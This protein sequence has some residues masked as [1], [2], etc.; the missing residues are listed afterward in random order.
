ME[1]TQSVQL[2]KS[3]TTETES[4][5]HVAVSEWGGSGHAS[6]E[7]ARVKESTVKT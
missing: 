1:Q 2:S 5:S 4:K 6:V 7:D 3:P